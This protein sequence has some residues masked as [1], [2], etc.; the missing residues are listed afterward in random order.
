[1]QPQPGGV[2]GTGGLTPL[3]EPQIAVLES[4]NSLLVNATP[5]QHAAIVMVISHVD[6]Q[7]AE[8]AIPYVVYPLEFQKPSELKTSLAEL[9]EKTIKDKEG[10]VTQTVSRGED[11]TIVAD[12]KA[13]SLIVYAN[14]KNQEWVGS[15]IRQ[16]D[17]K[18]PQVLIDVT[19]V[20]ITRDDGFQYALDATVGRQQFTKGGGPN[21]PP[22]VGLPLGNAGGIRATEFRTNKGTGQFFYSDNHI[23]ALLTAVKTKSYGRVLAKPKILVNDNEEGKISTTDTRYIAQSTTQ[24]PTAGSAITSTTFQAYDAKIELTIKPHI[25][26]GDL[27]LLEV[28]MKREDFRGTGTTITNPDG[29][30][31]QSPPNKTASDVDSKILVPDGATIILGGLL[32]L[33][34]NKGGSKVPILGDIP[35]IGGLFRSVDNSDVE[36][37]LYIFVKAYALRPVEGV[38]GLPEAEAIS[39]ENRAAFE[40]SERKFQKAD[41]FPWLKGKPMDP[42]KVLDEI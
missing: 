1:M 23:Q 27:L 10:K 32:K 33:N 3:E 41:D 14:K 18:R 31:V 28:K 8:V 26:E 16:L 35:I 42:N 25:S 15:L 17:K 34:Q 39:R 30:T 11:I 19:L 9:I 24:V 13:F 37:K 38:R 6:R 21:S 20:E 4:T 40:K 5:E 7:P 12:D 29:G 2:G 22:W 36:S